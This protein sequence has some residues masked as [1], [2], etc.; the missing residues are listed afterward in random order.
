MSW[1]RTTFAVLALALALGACAAAPQP[2]AGS[3]AEAT[4]SATPAPAGG[5]A[6]PLGPLPPAR[7][8]QA[9]IPPPPAG[10]TAPRQPLHYGPPVAQPKD[11]RG[12]QAC[13]LL[14]PAQLRSL[15]LDPTS[16]DQHTSGEAQVC[17]WATPDGTNTAGITLDSDRYP[18]PA[19]DGI[20]VLE[21]GITKVF[22]PITVAGH[23]GF[24]SDTDLTTCTYLIAVADYQLIGV[25][26]RA[27]DLPRADPC[28]PSRRM[29]ELILSNLPPLTS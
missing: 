4:P 21:K 14:T 3:A 11:A 8:G 13:D 20:Y 7:T 1:P 28:G 23:P 12:R 15:G 25:D 17:S 2:V 29:V 5:G 18:L 6:P 9:P 27:R 24:R 22:E 26:G 10:Q 16:A 19:L